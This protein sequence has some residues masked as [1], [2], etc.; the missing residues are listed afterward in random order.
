MRVLKSLFLLLALAGVCHAQMY[1]GQQL[2]NAQLIADADAIVPGHPITIGL[3]LQALPGWH[4][5]WQYAGDA[6]LPTS[7][8]WTLSPGFTAGPIQ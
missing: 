5:Y 4:T 3:R 2:V 8:E 6:G 7:I 1:E